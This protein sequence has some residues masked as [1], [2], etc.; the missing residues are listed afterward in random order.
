MAFCGMLNEME[1]TLPITRMKEGTYMFGTAKIFGT[2]KNKTLMIR[3]SS[4]AVMEASDFLA[5]FA[6]KEEEKCKRKNMQELNALHQGKLDMRG[7]LDNGM[8]TQVTPKQ[9]KTMAVP[10]GGMSPRL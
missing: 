6:S 9:R 1:L 4:G 8:L 10:R 2:I 3:S 5:N 7:A